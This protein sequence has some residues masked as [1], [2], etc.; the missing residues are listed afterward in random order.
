MDARDL[1]RVVEI[2]R[3][4]LPEAWTEAGFAAEI[5]APTCVAL[6]LERDD[7]VAAFGFGSVA[8]DELEIRALAVATG[9]RRGGIGRALTEAL[10]RAALARGA[11]VAHL[12]VRAGNAPALALYSLCGFAP[13]GRRAAYYGNGEDAVLMSRA[14]TASAPG[15]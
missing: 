11:R 7:G 6:V 13:S 3:A 14:L 4:S 10:L 2:A 8:A 5:A 9:V 12:E 1:P 15:T